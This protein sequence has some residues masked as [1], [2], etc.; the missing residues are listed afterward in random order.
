MRPLWPVLE[1]GKVPEKR[2]GA[3]GKAYRWNPELI[4]GFRGVGSGDRPI[5]TGCCSAFISVCSVPDSFA[6]PNFFSFMDSICHFT[7]VVHE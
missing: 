4:G 7:L 5:S 6:P 2:A 1:H 3:P